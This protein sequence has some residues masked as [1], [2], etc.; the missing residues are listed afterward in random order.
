MTE[1]QKFDPV[2]LYR[3]QFMAGPRIP[4]PFCAWPVIPFSR[5]LLIACHPEL[6]VATVAK[7]GRSMVCLGHILDPHSPGQG[8]SQVLESLLAASET[9]SDLERALAKLGG[10]WVLFCSMQEQQRVYHDAGGLK[11]VFFYADPSSQDLWICSQPGLL[12]EGL[13]LHPDVQLVKKFWATRF[14]NSWVC[15][16]TPYQHVRQLLPN[17]FLDVGRRASQRFWPS[18]N[19]EPQTL[20]GAAEKMAKIIHGLIA[21]VAKRGPVALPLTGGYESRVSFSCAGDL[22]ETI[23]LYVVD[24]PNTLYYDRV[25]SR[26]VAKDFGLQISSFHGVP[27]DERF[28]RTI[29]KNTAEMWWDQG[30]NHLSILDKHVPNHYLLIGAMGTVARA[31]YYQDGKL[32]E[33]IDARLLANVIGFA[34]NELVTAVLKDW[35]ETV[36]TGTNVSAL[37]LLFWEHRQGNWASMT[38]TAIDSV[39]CDTSAPFNS[40]ELMEIA[41]GVSVEYRKPP[42]VL[43]RRICV[44]MGGEKT[45]SVPINHYWLDSIIKRVV[46]PIPYRLKEWYF[47]FKMKRSGVPSCALSDSRFY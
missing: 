17:H 29:L 35:H 23:P 25:L 27:F 38:S 2:M 16:F 6:Q 11:S 14:H 18:V 1:P 20:E 24:A 21:A 33:S 19:V 39:G 46:A 4:A 42:H 31:W 13:G 47:K 32:P 3:R 28:W 45:V 5:T 10:R 44:M 22:R 34:G 30:G 15:E 12:E 9:F 8:N 41:L 43:L 7:E 40:R 37:D 36:P 26:R